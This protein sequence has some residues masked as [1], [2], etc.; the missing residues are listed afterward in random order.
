MWKM[1]SLF[2]SLPVVKI[3]KQSMDLLTSC[4]SSCKSVAS[5]QIMPVEPHPGQICIDGVNPIVSI[6]RGLCRSNR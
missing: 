3:R 6:K 4:M 2:A 1:A 5:A